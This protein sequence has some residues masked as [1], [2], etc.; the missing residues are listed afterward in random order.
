MDVVATSRERCKSGRLPLSP[1]LFVALLIGLA[2]AALRSAIFW[3]ALHYEWTGRGT[4][5]FVPLL[6]LLKPEIDYFP[7][8]GEWTVRSAAVFNALLLVTS[9]VV[10]LLVSAAT[11]YVAVL[12][13][14]IAT[15]RND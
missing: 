9:V 3:I 14:Q 15:K 12:G 11:W 6:P 13:R 1:F 7:K 10:A 8:G 5:A 4:L 2:T